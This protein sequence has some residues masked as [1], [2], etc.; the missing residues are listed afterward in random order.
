M[1]GSNVD[2]VV[3]YRDAQQEWRWRGVARNGE[4]VAEGESHTRADDAARAA[5]GVFGDKVNIILERGKA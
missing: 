2:H 5:E 1:T 3:V 4:I